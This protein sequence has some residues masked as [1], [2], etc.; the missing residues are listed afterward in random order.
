MTSFDD[1]RRLNG[2]ALRE[3]LRAGDARD[4]VQAA[5]ALGLALGAD[6][7]REASERADRDPDPGV[8]RHLAV[9]LASLGEAAALRELALGDPDPYVRATAHRYALRV[10]AAGVAQAIADAAEAVESDE[11]DVVREECLRLLERRW[12]PDRRAVLLAALAHPALGVRRAAFERICE[13]VS[14]E[15]VAALADR[16]V[17]EQDPDLLRAMVD[18]TIAQPGGG[19]IL[20]QRLASLNVERAG[21][22]LAV[23]TVSSHELSWDDL[24]PIAAREIPALDYLVL[25]L[26]RRP[27]SGD[28]VWLA[29]CAARR[30][31]AG[32]SATHDVW[33]AGW[34]A[35]PALLA[36]IETVDVR[37]LSARDR[38]PFATLIRW[39]QDEEAALRAPDP[40]DDDDPDYELPEEYLD[41]VVA[42]RR[43]LESWLDA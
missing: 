23:A 4:R 37:R 35:R 8:R 39:L 6:F 12:P 42:Q 28:V 7:A 31:V 9:M 1:I 17:V 11:S 19:A 41:Q 40:W 38:E 15:S 13:A 21:E 24:A 32:R 29:R 43:A 16:A 18:A 5:W 2:R 33:Q 36:K 3:L 30:V 25:R 27:E 10:P 20:G 34:L 26:L 14:T 22:I